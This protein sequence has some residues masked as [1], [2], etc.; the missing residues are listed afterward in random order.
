MTHFQMRQVWFHKHLVLKN[1]KMIHKTTYLKVELYY[2]Q[3]DLIYKVNK[4]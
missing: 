4:G 1:N 3:K 2:K